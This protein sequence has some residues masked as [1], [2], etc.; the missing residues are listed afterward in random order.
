[1][2]VTVGPIVPLPKEKRTVF[3]R[4]GN[5][6]LGIVSPEAAQA[7]SIH[8]GFIKLLHGVEGRNGG[9]GLAHIESKQRVEHFKKL[10]FDEII[11]F[12]RFVAEEYDEFGVQDDGKVVFQRHRDQLIHQVICLWDEDLK[13]WSVTTAIAKRAERNL[14][15]CWKR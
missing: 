6:D 7:A 12:V 2:N 1:M 10:G 15:I 8:P 4:N 5:G 13:I 3:T 11:D 14:K 9:F